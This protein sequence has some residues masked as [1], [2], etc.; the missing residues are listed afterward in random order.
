MRTVGDDPLIVYEQVLENTGAAFLGSFK[1]LVLLDLVIRIEA[2][3][4][5]LYIRIEFSL[6]LEENMLLS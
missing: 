6:R 5:I 3:V 2:D 1:H 4:G